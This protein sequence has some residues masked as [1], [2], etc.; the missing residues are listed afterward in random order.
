MQ[1]SSKLHIAIEAPPWYEIP[2]HGYGGIE[3]ICYW[4]VNGLVARGHQVTLVRAAHATYDGDVPA[5]T[6][7]HRIEEEL[8][9]AGVSVLDRVDLTFP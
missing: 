8:G 4:L 2:P 1:G 3:W 7:S 9:A 5:E 6:T